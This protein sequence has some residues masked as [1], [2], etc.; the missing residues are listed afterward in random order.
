MMSKVT[1]EGPG[2]D[3][4]GCGDRQAQDQEAETRSSLGEVGRIQIP[5]ATRGVAL[6]V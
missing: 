3:Q 5:G 2:A 6:A 1:N 4:Q